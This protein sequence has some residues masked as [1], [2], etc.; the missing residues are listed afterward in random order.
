M[1]KKI[2]SI[3]RR[4]LRFFKRKDKNIRVDIWAKELPKLKRCS[5]LVGKRHSLKTQVRKMQKKGIK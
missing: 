4:F 1:I 2:L 5:L 3:I